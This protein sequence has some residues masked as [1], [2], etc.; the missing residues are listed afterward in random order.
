MPAAVSGLTARVTLFDTAGTSLNERTARGLRVGG[1][2][3]GDGDG[4]GVTTTALTI[5]AVPASADGPEPTDPVRLA[6]ADS[7]GREVSRNVSWLSTRPHDRL[8]DLTGRNSLAA[9]TVSGPR[10]PRATPTRSPPPRSPSATPVAGGR[11][12]C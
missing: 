4:D 8:R 10:A 12:R 6:L 7:A 2:G 5:P 1:G 11:P 3:D 9:A